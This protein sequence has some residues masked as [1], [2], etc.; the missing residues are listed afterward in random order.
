MVS[1]LITENLHGW[2]LRPDGAHRPASS[3]VST[4]V[5]LM[6]F[7]LYLRMERLL[8][9]ADKTG[10]SFNVFSVIFIVRLIAVRQAKVLIARA[11]C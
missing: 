3:I 6:C 9:I 5:S 7:A 1:S 11:Y 10:L 4:E 2:L 8:R